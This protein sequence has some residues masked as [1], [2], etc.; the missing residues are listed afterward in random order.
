MPTD[1][2]YINYYNTDKYKYDKEEANSGNVT[3][4]ITFTNSKSNHHDAMCAVCMVEGHGS[5]VVMPGTDKCL[6]S[7]WTME[8]N[9]YT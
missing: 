3:G 8:Y 1:K 2:E 9:G 4:Y 7:S 5:I 6:D